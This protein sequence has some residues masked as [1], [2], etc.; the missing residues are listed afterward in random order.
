MIIELLRCVAADPFGQGRPQIDELAMDQDSV[1]RPCGAAG[2]V[3]GVLAGWA[4]P[5]RDSI[6][7]SSSARAGQTATIRA[8]QV[9]CAAA[10][11]AAIEA[12]TPAA[13]AIRAIGRTRRPGRWSSTEATEAT[14]TLEPRLRHLQLR[15][16]PVTEAKQALILSAQL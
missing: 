9:G 10:M 1:P 12:A 2:S 7:T 6:S 15:L 14:C 8:P 16:A 11:F 3:A 13:K 5:E 4:W